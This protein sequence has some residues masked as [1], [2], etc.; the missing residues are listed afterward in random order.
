MI[1]EQESKDMI[2]YAM[3][4]LRSEDEVAELRILDSGKGT[5]S[6]YFTDEE[7]LARTALKY[8]GQ[9]GI[10]VT[11]NPVKKAL[12]ARAENRAII[13]AK[14]TTS[15]SDIECRR[16][17]M[18]DLDPVR[19]SGISSTDEEHDAAIYMAKEIMKYLN[20]Q[21]WSEPV[22]AD[23][24]NGAHLLYYIDLPND[25]YS[26][27]LVKKILN[28]LDIKF[29]DNVVQ[30]DTTTYNASRILKL[31]GTVAC[32]GD[33]TAERPHRSSMI[34]ECPE[35]IS[36]VPIELLEELSEQL[37]QIEEPKKKRG[38]KD[39]N[40]I[41]N[42]DEWLEENKIAIAFKGRW[43][44]KGTKYVLEICPWNHNRT[45]RSAFI[46]KF[47]DGGIVAGC[48][49]NSCRS[50]NWHTLKKLFGSDTEEIENNKALEGEKQADIL[51]RL[52]SE[53]KFFK[54]DMD[55]AFVAIEING[56]T[57][58]CKVKGRQYK[59]WLTMKYYTETGKAPST[60]AMNQALGIMEM[61][62]LFSGEQ[63]E[64][65]L[66]VAEL[67]G[68]IYYDLADKDWR[69]VKIDSNGCKILEKPPILFVRNKNMKSQ[70]QPDFDGDIKL[71]LKH[72]RIKNP[73]E[74]I[75]YL[76]YVVSCFVP[77]IPHP[78]L[79]FCGEKGAAKTTGLR[80]TRAVIDPAV[81]DLLIMP[82]GIQDL[83]LAL[84]NN[85]M[86][87]FDNLDT[88]SSDKSDLLC[89]AST[90]GG[91]SKRTLFTDDD[92]TILS[93]KRCVGMN[94][95]NVVVTRAD[96]LDRSIIE[97]LE[98][99]DES[100]RKEEKEIWK[101]FEADMPQIVGGALNT[102]SKAMSIYPNVKLNR[103]ARMADFTRWGYAIAEALGIG[104][105]AFLDAYF[106]NQN[107]SNEEAISSH[108]VASAIVALMKSTT[109]WNGTVAELLGTLERVA[110][111]E[112]INTHVKVWPNAAHIL[113][114]RLKEV[115]SN[116]KQVGITFDIRHMGTAK[117]INIKR[118]ENMA[119]GLNDSS[120]GSESLNQSTMLR[121]YTP[122]QIEDVSEDYE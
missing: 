11:L 24:G 102:L 2:T 74:Q 54:N 84:A 38:K 15:D 36:D 5:I 104:G 7:V 25:E 103:L 21:G 100:E 3:N 47:D 91:F 65:Q 97:E 59:M 44:N 39:S 12:L 62:A 28:V 109:N 82:N 121:R 41:S 29:S 88:L 55:E 30:V 69:V 16:W 20:E 71:L 18:I 57:E 67:D 48:L 19:P 17:I 81:R 101:D 105:E 106:S 86:P 51:I 66:R 94:G 76:V 118:S 34:L 53:S 87:C 56:H 46:I 113:S 68:T 115:Q 90:G 8:N 110:E 70:V 1:C 117:V 64:L 93:F 79:V 58:L 27:Q 72:I 85:Y 73:T 114:R 40:D 31:Y 33:N 75:L 98:R 80:M 45:N 83:A 26:C 9:T 23:S 60:D 122:E 111:I 99:I 63:R 42:I 119:I 108:P 77:S 50:E 13:R 120:I 14:Q 61:K 35:E 43:Q 10:Y 52:G 112:K 32:K 6:G 89:T 92:E 37:P 78:V 107:K 22:L 95:I 4:V 96:L 49:H 116:L